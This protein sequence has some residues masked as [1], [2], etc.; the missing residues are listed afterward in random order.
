MTGVLFDLDGTLLDTLEDLTASVNHT[1]SLWELPLRTREQ[2]RCFVGNGAAKLIERSLPG[3]PS[4]P[5]LQE[6]LFQY[7][8]YYD[9]HCQ[10]QTAPYP[11]I[12]ELLEAVAEKCPVG[13]VS[14]KPH[15]STEPLCSRFFPGIYALGQQAALPKKPAPDMLL[16]AMEELNLDRCIYVGDSEV[17]ILTA[18][19]AGVPC[20]SVTWGFRDEAVLRQAG[21]QHFCPHPAAFLKIL[22][23]VLYGQ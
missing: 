17:D 13:I 21:G 6:A 16:R 7:Q 15:V 1:L 5:P 12:P 2:V 23:E 4:D 20:I 9:L 8:Q 19:N 22:D 18:K 3:T 11:G 14:N 10:D